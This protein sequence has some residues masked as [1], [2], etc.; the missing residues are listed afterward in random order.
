MI[1]PCWWGG[2]ALQETFTL[3]EDRGIHDT[4]VGGV[5]GTKIITRQYNK[6]VR[7]HHRS[8]KR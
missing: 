5:S 6:L 2:G 7:D 3:W 4:C 8:I 1:P